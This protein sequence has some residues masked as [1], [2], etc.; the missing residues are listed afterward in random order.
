M[1]SSNISIV[2]GIHAYKDGFFYLSSK[3]C[4]IRKL[5]IGS[6]PLKTKENIRF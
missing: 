5:D 6:L 4:G 2:K 1:K 3:L